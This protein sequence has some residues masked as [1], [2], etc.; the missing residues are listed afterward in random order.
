MTITQRRQEKLIRLKRWWYENCVEDPIDGSEFDI[1]VLSA[2][3]AI[4]KE[5]CTVKTRYLTKDEV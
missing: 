5:Y 2:I 3:E 1:A 4:E